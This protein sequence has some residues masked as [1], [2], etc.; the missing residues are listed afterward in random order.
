MTYWQPRALPLTNLEG[1][2]VLDQP[3]NGSETNEILHLLDQLALKYTG[4]TLK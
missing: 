3:S 4:E 1:N 2:V